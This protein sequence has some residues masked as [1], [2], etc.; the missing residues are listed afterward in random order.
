M[1][2]V[3][4]STFTDF[5]TAIAVSGDIVILDTDLDA[6][7]Q[8]ITDTVIINCAEIDGAGHTIY[9][10]QCTRDIY[11]FRFSNVC[12]LHH[13][14]I[15]NV[16]QTAGAALFACSRSD[17]IVITISNCIL[18]GIFTGICRGQFYFLQCAFI[19]Q[20]TGALAFSYYYDS[21][22]NLKLDKCYF[23]C[24]NINQNGIC[25]VGRIIDCYF[26]GTINNPVA[27][28]YIFDVSGT[29]SVLNIF[30]KASNAVTVFYGGSMV[31]PCIYNADR[32]DS[33]ITL[34]YEYTP[35]TDAQ[36]HSA[37]EIAATGFDIIV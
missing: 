27:N 11:V 37:S 34:R 3:H 33:T 1:A 8:E 15:Q 21:R 9:N 32:V 24:D 22:T 29:N 17:D 36:M 13:C 35:L 4:V 19:L 10:V 16:L 2:V 26:E 20:R 25:R 12:N 30:I 6:N 18:Q 7:A 5:L 23:K 28:A 31:S 14:N